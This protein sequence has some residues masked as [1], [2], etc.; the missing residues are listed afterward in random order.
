MAVAEAMI[1]SFLERIGAAR[2]FGAQLEF[3]LIVSALMNLVAA[4]AVGLLERK[5]MALKVAPVGAL[6]PYRP[7]RA[8]PTHT[9]RA[10]RSI[11]PATCARVST[12]RPS[13]LSIGGL[14]ERSPFS[15]R[16]L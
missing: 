12:L 10:T 8:E 1:F 6:N 14:T 16:Q 9:G 15:L 11:I 13:Q 3:V 5:L 4:V 2:G 7:I